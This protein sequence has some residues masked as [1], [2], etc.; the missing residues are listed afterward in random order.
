LRNPS[1]KKSKKR[2]SFDILQSEEK[3]NSQP[4]AFDNFDYSKRI[5]GSPP[6]PQHDSDEDIFD[7]GTATIPKFVGHFVAARQFGHILPQNQSSPLNSSPRL[8]AQAEA[9]IAADREASV[10]QPHSPLSPKS[11]FR[12]LKSRKD[13]IEE[14]SWLRERSLE[15][16]QTSPRLPEKR[17][18]NLMASFDMD[19]AL[20]DM[21]DFLGD[22]WSVDAELKKAKGS[23]E[24]ESRGHRESNGSKRR[25]LFG[26]V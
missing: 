6:P 16:L 14:G 19:D 25:R 3:E 10:E 11:P 4:D 15:S 12:K 18:G 22:S 8:S 20:D 26:L 7:D 23:K 2:V 9:F 21:S 17:V 13:E 24:S 1:L 5:P